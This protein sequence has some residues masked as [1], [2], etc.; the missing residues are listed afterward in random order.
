MT[1]TLPLEPQQE[2]RLVA[3]A[4]AKGLSLDAFV[5]EVIDKALAE[6]PQ[7]SSASPLTPEER[8]TAFRN[9]AESFP[10]HRNVPLSDDAISR[11]A[12]YRSDPE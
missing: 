6:T 5:R 8:A 4:R 3:A 12:F 11:D 2:A 7:Q 1:I 9:W 10:H